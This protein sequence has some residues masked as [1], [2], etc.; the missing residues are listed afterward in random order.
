MTLRNSGDATMDNVENDVKL[1]LK[2]LKS[3]NDLAELFCSHLN[4]KYMGKDV[5]RRN[6]IPKVTQSIRDLQLIAAHDEFKVFWIGLDTP[7]LRRTDERNIIN[8]LNGE[9]PYNLG[10]FSNSKNTEWDFV[11]VKLVSDNGNKNLLLNKSRI[12]RRIHIDEFE[13]MRTATE[14]I[15]RLN[16]E[17][18]SMSPLEL[19]KR[20]DKA[21]DVEEVTEK[22][23]IGDVRGIIREKGFI[24]IF[25]DLKS[26]LLSQAGDEKWSH[27]YS[28]QF[29]SRIMFLYFI[30]RKRW[31]GENPEF[32]ETYWKKY[33]NAAPTKNSFVSSWLATLFFEAFN[34]GYTHP[35]WMPRDLDETIA[36]APYLNGGLFR[37]N[38][39]DKLHSV[40]INDYDFETIFEF[41]QRYNFTITEDSPLDQLVAVDPEMIG[42]VYE[43]LIRISEIEERTE[44]PG[45][46][47]TPRTEI[48][49]MCR[50]ALV[51]R[52]INE[53]G[54]EHRNRF[55][56]MAFAFED[57][58][59]EQADI[60]IA[61]ANL[62][63]NIKKFIQK[64]TLVDPAVGSGSFLVG[65]LSLLTDLTRRA[66]SKIGIPES[67][68]E[69]KKRIIGNS[70]YGVDVRAWAVHVCELRLWLQLIVETEYDII[71][72][73]KDP[74][75]PN[76]TFNIWQGDSLVQEIGGINLPH[77]KFS[78]ISKDISARIESL[79][80]DKLK[81]YECQ[82]GKYKEK[83]DIEREEIDIFKK[84]LADQIN[85]SENDLKRIRLILNKGFED[86]LTF[87]GISGSKPKQ[88]Q[89]L[90]SQYRD[91]KEQLENEI[92]RLKI[93]MLALNATQ[94]IPFVWEIGF[95]EIFAKDDRG[96]D[97]VIGNPP[98]I[99][100][101]LIAD[102]QEMK[103][104][105]SEDKWREHKKAYKE[106]L[107]R[108]IYQTYP[109]FFNYQPAAGK[110][111]RKMDAKNDLYVYFYLHGLSLLN[112][113]GSFCF[114]TSNSWLDVGYG[115][116]LQEFLIKNVPIRMII[117][118]Q[119]KR[120]FK[121]ADVNTVICLFRS[122]NVL[123][124]DKNKPKFIMF[125]VPFE[126]V[127]S[128]F[129][130]EEIEECDERK[131]T[132]EYRVLTKSVDD[133][134]T[135]GVEIDEQALT[136]DT[137]SAKYI[138]NKWGGKYLRAPDIYYTIL[139]KGKG[140]LVRLGD[141]ADIRFGIKTG[142]NEFFY[143]TQEKIE[144]WGIEEE[145]VKPFL[146]SLKE[147]DNYEVSL[148]RLKKS[149]FVCDES[150]DALYKKGKL[151]A[152]NYIRW[153]E[154]EGYSE[155]PSVSGRKLWYEI[156][157]QMK[158]DFVSNRFL[159]ER[160]GFPLNSDNLVCDVF[161]VGSFL[162]ND[163]FL[164]TCLLNSTLSYL[165]VEVI[166]RKTYGIG[167][168]Y[169]YGPEINNTLLLNPNILNQKQSS[170]IK[171]I[172]SKM[173]KREIVKIQDEIEYFDRRY[174]D[175]LVF[176]VIGLTKNER[177]EV[178]S[179]LC[180]MVQK[181]LEKAKN[182]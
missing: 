168:A 75:L 108:S 139:E 40:K 42:K 120:S 180:E 164:S 182:I 96:F 130:L 145:Y 128:P 48:A 100:Q 31:L 61:E 150:K 104:K 148:N 39:L 118:N 124:G 57:E 26:N 166:A 162:K 29:L 60:S 4:Y 14:R 131:V 93:A 149:I 15:S 181:R 121:N 127:L 83:I 16:I 115:K 155:R 103:E 80:N 68:Y 24:H 20:H 36:N 123:P 107:M 74:L 51:D 32:L 27:D 1:A 82:T 172:F 141:I 153:G 25:E 3:P 98:Y 86:Q 5:S 21:F 161:F 167:V 134:L 99:R 44:S 41:Y 152:F 50:L 71:D 73:Q 90:E 179:S 33:E 56:E 175:E 81:Y 85:N 102:P 106:R 78:T 132:N 160:F 9:N 59:K 69:I 109:D 174:I 136:I 147:I 176:D 111:N 138:G 17:D 2:K 55:Y 156:P 10:I 46:V 8:K 129:F 65:M 76:L 54:K 143:L 163:P 117:D 113:K 64:I 67:D 101:E 18:E 22:F 87:T 159:G 45:V 28:L 89:L 105:F 154:K 13:R 30:Q 140:K 72:L 35:Q 34:K 95:A 43:S 116:D 19:Q 177:E 142:A 53:F 114:V 62:W 133:L 151:G 84:I 169:I 92:N 63:H 66:N 125:K 171:D 144:E 122:P 173:R 137:S 6:W 146:F 165:S 112:K 79:K 119:I 157:G 38:E 135:E 7:T 12:M 126:Q 58:E 37:P 23:F 52:L 158:I 77:L 47:Y 110:A 170:S 88:L 91:K 70:L 94:K 11:N 178:Y 49:L 97:I